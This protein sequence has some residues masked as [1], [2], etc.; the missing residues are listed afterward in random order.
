M[1]DTVFM[2]RP[3]EPD[4]YRAVHKFT[5]PRAVRGTL[6]LPSVESWRKR[7]A[8]HWL[9]LTRLELTVYTDNAPAIRPYEKF[10]FV[11][12]SLHRRYAYRDGAW[13]DVYAVARL[14]DGPP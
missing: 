7:P 3:T 10:G 1:P 6:Q 11:R 13:A 9:G 12:E 4:G 5:Y 8:D 2:V 14:R